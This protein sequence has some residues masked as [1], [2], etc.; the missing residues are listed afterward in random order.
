MLSVSGGAEVFWRQLA[1]HVTFEED[2]QKHATERRKAVLQ[3]FAIQKVRA[4]RE[5]RAQM[6]L[7]KQADAQHDVY[8]RARRAP[9]IDWEQVVKRWAEQNLRAEKDVKRKKLTWLS[10]VKLM[11]TARIEFLK[12]ILEAQAQKHKWGAKRKKRI[13]KMLLQGTHSRTL[14]SFARQP[15]RAGMREWRSARMAKSRIFLARAARVRFTI[16]S[17]LKKAKREARR[18]ARTGKKEKTKNWIPPYDVSLTI[19]GD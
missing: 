5:L 11:A 12:R 1:R 6:R 10:E 9:K 13:E 14:A 3:K 7:E 8:R 19:Y 16:R 17:L 18:F 2:L 15:L 4:R